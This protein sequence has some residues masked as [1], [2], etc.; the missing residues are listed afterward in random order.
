MTFEGGAGEIFHVNCQCYHR[1]LFSVEQRPSEA[2]MSLNMSFKWKNK[3]SVLCHISSSGCHLFKWEESLMWYDFRVRISS[4]NLLTPWWLKFQ[5]G[6]QPFDIRLWIVFPL[7][8]YTSP[9]IRY[10]FKPYESLMYYDLIVNLFVKFFP[11][12]KLWLEGQREY[13]SIHCLVCRFGW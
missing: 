2:V 5:K 10:E 9:C 6:F 13:E 3:A 1:R 11:E 12:I 8:K 7:V 4:F